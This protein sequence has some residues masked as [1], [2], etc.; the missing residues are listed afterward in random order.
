MRYKEKGDEEKHQDVSMSAIFATR[1]RHR[2][3]WLESTDQVYG[4]DFNK[5]RRMVDGREPISR[6]NIRWS[7]AGTATKI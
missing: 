3:L 4:G 7:D 2:R 6:R 1:N 5:V